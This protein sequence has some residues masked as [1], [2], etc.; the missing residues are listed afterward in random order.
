MTELHIEYLG[1]KGDGIASHEGKRV[2]V[3]RG[4]ANEIVEAKLYKT[5]DNIDRASI[6]SIKTPSPTRQTAPCTHYEECGGC[7]MQHLKV[8]D[9]R[10]WKVD[11]VRY[12]L[13]KNISFFPE[14]LPPIFIPTGTRRRASF[15]A[16]KQN[17]RVIIGYNKRRSKQITD[18]KECLILHP[19]LLALKETL[20][21]HLSPL[22]REGKTYDLFLQKIGDSY[23]CVITG[24]KGKQDLS[25]HETI[26]SLI[27][28]TK[29]TRI[30]WRERDRDKPEILLEKHALHAPMGKLNVPLPPLAFLQ[31]SHEGEQALIQS[32]ISGLP[33]DLKTGA[34]LFSGNGTFIGHLLAQGY[35]M[36]AYESESNAIFALKRAGLQKATERDLFKTPLTADELKRFDFVVLDPPRAGARNQCEELA[37]STVKHIAYVSCN[38]SSFARDAEALLQGGYR[39][40]SIQIVDQFPWSTHIEIIVHLHR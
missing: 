17:K 32:V 33:K 26:A 6:L 37:R 31:P 23:D 13:E 2:F 30:S 12:A 28:T 38:P 20:K 5:T 15:T 24:S 22:L 27:H 39:I 1:D 29:I 8:D 11:A 40:Q 35:D 7:Q 19:D 14:F 3:D 21:S 4:L 25:F 16:V 9:Y 18:I 34:D 10:H 36:S